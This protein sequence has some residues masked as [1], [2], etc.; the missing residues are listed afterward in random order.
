M[1]TKRPS[2]ERGHND[3][4]WLDTYHTFSFSSYFDP[5]HTHFR[6]LRVINEDIVQPGG[7]FPTHPHD[8]MEILTYI[9]DGA[10]EHQDSMGNG[11]V[12]RP[13]Q[14]Q[15]MTAGTGI[16]HSEFNPS[17]TE[18]V[19]LLQIWMLPEE[20]G[21]EPSY[22]E[23]TFNIEARKA[24]LQLIASRDGREGSAVIHQD[25]ALYTSVLTENDSVHHELEPNRHAWIQVTR[26][27]ILLNEIELNAGDGAAVSDEQK[28]SV[29]GTANSEVLLF[30]LP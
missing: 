30:D 20:K 19:H 10:L 14:I 17:K 9:L 4:G 1:I 18:P 25:L 7:G 15:T 2:N 22:G 12:I 8:N 3:L 11:S 28:L 23:Y 13:G 6:A 24:D 21:L 16:T 27:S 29:T 26:G 5:N